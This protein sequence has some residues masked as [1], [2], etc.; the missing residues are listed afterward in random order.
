MDIITKLRKPVGHFE[1]VGAF[2]HVKA[3]HFTDA[4]TNLRETSVVEKSALWVQQAQGSDQKE[5]LN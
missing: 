5:I 2:S 1:M 4:A 3:L